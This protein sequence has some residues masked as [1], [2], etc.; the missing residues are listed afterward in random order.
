MSSRTVYRSFPKHRTIR[1]L[2][3]SYRQPNI[4]LLQ[5]IN[6]TRWPSSHL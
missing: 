4:P 6:D 2:W 5:G 1:P 3:N